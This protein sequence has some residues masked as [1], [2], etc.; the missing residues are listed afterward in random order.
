M[1]DDQ[2]ATGEAVEEIHEMARKTDRHD[3]E[4]LRL[5]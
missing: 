2:S 5:E 4:N 1:E 3:G